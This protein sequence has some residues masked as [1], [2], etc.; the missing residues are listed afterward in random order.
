MCAK[1]GCKKS[2]RVDAETLQRLA[3]HLAVSCY[4]CKQGALKSTERTY[5]NILR[6]Q[7]PACNANNTWQGIIA[8]LEKP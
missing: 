2:E 4:S 3:D 5:G 7:N 6:C 8:R 1:T